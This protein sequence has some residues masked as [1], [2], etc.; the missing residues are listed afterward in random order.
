MMPIEKIS[1]WGEYKFYLRDS[2]GIYKGVPT[3][4]FD[5]I[6]VSE[7][8]A[9]PKSAIFHPFFPFKMLAGLI[10]LWMIPFWNKYFNPSI[11]CWVMS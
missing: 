8:M 7:K 3:L 10:S 4:N 2:M 6:S 5:L 11:I 9:N 1:L